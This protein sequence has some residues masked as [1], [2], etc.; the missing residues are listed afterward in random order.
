M[1]I[2]CQEYDPSFMLEVNK[3]S[4][5]KTLLNLRI[6]PTLSST[7]DSKGAKNV[8]QRTCTYCVHEVLGLIHNKNK[9]NIT[10]AN[11][12]L[13]LI[14]SAHFSITYQTLN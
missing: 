2:L 8:A 6:E 7:T 3:K 1:K 11:R 12:I 14:R 5:E 10:K 9:T 13:L 4:S